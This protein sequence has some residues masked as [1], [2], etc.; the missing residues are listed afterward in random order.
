MDT[1]RSLRQLSTLLRHGA[2]SD[3]SPECASK[4][5]STD[6]SESPTEGEDHAGEWALPGG[7]LRD[8]ETPEQAAVRDVFE[9]TQYHAGHASQWHCRRAQDG[10]DAITSVYDCDDEF[11][12]RLNREHTGFLW[13]DPREAL[14][15]AGVTG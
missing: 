4:R 12:P 9:E 14:S 5:K 3:L 7:K 13:L 11:T 10:V 2:M 6:H 1:G 8:G 15:M